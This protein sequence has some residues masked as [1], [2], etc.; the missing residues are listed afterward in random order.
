MNVCIVACSLNKRLKR[1]DLE[2]T[3]KKIE[4]QILFLLFF[5]L[6]FDKTLNDLKKTGKTKRVEENSAPTDQ[7]KKKKQNKHPLLEVKK[8]NKTN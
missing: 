1:R 8:Q 3:W 4:N 2:R 7:H 5:S 6:F